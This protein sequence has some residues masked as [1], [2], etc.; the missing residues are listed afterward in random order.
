MEV[1]LAF[2]R[3]LERR[4]WPARSR[5]VLACCH[6]DHDPTDNDPRNLAALC[7]RCPLEHDR[8][9]T[10][11]AAAAATVRSGRER[12]RVALDAIGDL[13]VRRSVDDGQ[14]DPRNGV[15]FERS[16]SV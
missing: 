14:L 11:T 2:W 1:Q 10:R 4:S 7:Q 15:R 9:T 12:W 3:G 5:V 8:T 13:T 6:L 16:V